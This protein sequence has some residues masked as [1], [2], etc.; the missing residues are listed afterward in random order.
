MMTLFAFGVTQALAQPVVSDSVAFQEA[1]SVAPTQWEKLA[2]LSGA[3]LVYSGID[4][5]GYNLTRN[6]K[7]ALVGYRIFQVMMQAALS[8][9]LYDQ[10]GLPTAIGFN[11]IWWTFGCDF[12]YYGYSELFN[13]GGK[14]ESRGALSANVMGNHA[15]WAYWTPIG[16]MRG[17]K[18]NQPIAGSTLVA[19]S[20]IGAAIGVS[21]SLV[22]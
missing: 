5:V 8:W 6:D 14:W 16:I 7:T 4:Y 22:F 2:Y 1:R 20:L 18:R 11:L 19:Q 9:L 17:M 13:P 21:V 3:V 15:T 10:V 12:T